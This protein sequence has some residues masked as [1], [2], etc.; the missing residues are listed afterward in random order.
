MRTLHSF[1]SFISGMKRRRDAFL[2]RMCKNRNKFDPCYS[3]N[4]ASCAENPD[5]V[6]MEIF[7]LDVNANAPTKSLVHP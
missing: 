5:F 2:H 4:L 7:R 6:R 1:L 3:L